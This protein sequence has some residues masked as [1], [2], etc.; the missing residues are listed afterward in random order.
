MRPEVHFYVDDSGSRDPDRTRAAEWDEL[1]WYALGGILIRDGDK[2]IAK[3]LIADFRACWPQIAGRPFRSY[4]IRNKTER[5]RWLADLPALGREQFY[6]E[7]EHLVIRLPILVLACVIDRPGYNH[8]YLDEYG[9]RRWKLCRTAFAIAVERAVRFSLSVGA[10]LRVFVERSDRETERQF[11]D[12]FDLMRKEGLPFDPA[13]SSKYNPPPLDQIQRTL[14]EFAVKTKTSDL[15]QIADLVLWPVC[16]GGYHA[17]HRPYVALR[18]HG[19]L[20]DSLCTAGNGLLGVKYSCFDL[21][22]AAQKKQEPAVSG[23][24]SATVASGATS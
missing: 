20:L 11:R 21:V 19:K 2:D 12:Y 22:D 4:D 15:M 18:D 8:R 17:S 7:L 9:P 3:S 5:F 14:L 16:K 1:D 6:R 13:R 10:K 23:L 24:L